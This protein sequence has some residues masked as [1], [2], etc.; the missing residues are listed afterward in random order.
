MVLMPKLK[1][2]IVIGQSPDSGSLHPSSLVGDRRHTLRLVIFP[3]YG[4]QG[5]PLPLFLPCYDRP[6]SDNR[7]FGPGRSWSLIS[8]PSA[9]AFRTACSPGRVFKFE[10]A[11]LCDCV[12]ETIAIMD[13]Q[14][15]NGGVYPSNMTGMKPESVLPYNDYY[16]S[17]T[18]AGGEVT[19]S[20]NNHRGTDHAAIQHVPETNA[21]YQ[22]NGGGGYYSDEVY[23][24]YFEYPPYA[25]CDGGPGPWSFNYCYG[26]FGEA[27]CPYAN[28]IDMED[29][30]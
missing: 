19:G 4:C 14:S 17:G 16:P 23:P 10:V 8:L 27:P 5:P 12:T 2:S 30:M 22:P 24:S 18:G 21:N 25:P 29:F 15:S 28:V 6:G 9:E 13:W 11:D 1:T 7:Q 26:F 20:Y 3:S